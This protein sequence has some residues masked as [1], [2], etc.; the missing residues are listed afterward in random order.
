M[1]VNPIS[2]LAH[3]GT[4]RVEARMLCV[5]VFGVLQL[6]STSWDTMLM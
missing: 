5:L 6:H 3:V 1:V 2:N 4:V